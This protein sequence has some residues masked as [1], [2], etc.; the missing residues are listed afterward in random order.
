MKQVLKKF[1]TLILLFSALAMSAAADQSQKIYP[2]SS[3]AYRQLLLLSVLSGIAPPQ[4]PGRGVKLNCAACSAASRRNHLGLKLCRYMNICRS[5]CIPHDRTCRSVSRQH[6][7]YT[8]IPTGQSSSIRMRSGSSIIPAEVHPSILL[9]SSA[10]RTRSM[11][12]SI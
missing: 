9:L 11:D 7:R 2:V 1:T 12:S 5:S 6:R 8:C 4:I 10:S 3:P